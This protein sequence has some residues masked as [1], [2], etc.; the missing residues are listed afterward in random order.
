M[1]HFVGLFSSSELS[2]LEPD[3]RPK[4]ARHL[5]FRGAWG[6]IFSRLSFSDMVINVTDR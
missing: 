3:S 6:E 5:L 1:L 4:N 2:S